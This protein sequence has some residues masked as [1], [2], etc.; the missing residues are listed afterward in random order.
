MPTSDHGHSLT[1][2]VRELVSQATK[3]HFQVHSK[4][5]WNSGMIRGI[6]N[7]LKTQSLCQKTPGKTK[8]M[9]HYFAGT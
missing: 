1:Y 5:I 2:T 8:T 9:L 7:F 6:N 3:R 4:T